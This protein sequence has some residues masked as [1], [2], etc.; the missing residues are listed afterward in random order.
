MVTKSVQE[1]MCVC[2]CMDTKMVQFYARR[3]KELLGDFELASG[4]DAAPKICPDPTDHWAWSYPQSTYLAVGANVVFPASSSHPALPNVNA[5][6]TKCG[7]TR[8][9]LFQ[10]KC[11]I[12]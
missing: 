3:N 7:F 8:S 4:R 5:L 6:E 2:V 9:I 10:H 1:E 11:F 12:L